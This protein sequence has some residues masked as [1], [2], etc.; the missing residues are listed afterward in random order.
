MF[1][2]SIVDMTGINGADV[3]TEIVKFSILV[4]TLFISTIPLII[5][6]FTGE[7]PGRKLA[8]PFV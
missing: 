8:K 3:K 1:T 5:E 6:F 7:T 4:G 2:A